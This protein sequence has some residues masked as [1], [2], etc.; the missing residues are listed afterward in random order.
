[1]ENDVDDGRAPPEYEFIYKQ[2][3][4]TTDAFL[5][6]S[7][8]DGSSACCE[9]IVLRVKLPDVQKASEIDVDLKAT[10]IRLVTAH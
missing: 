5:G 10:S 6:M 2:A 9:D 8:K 3:V 1:M 7:G 4:E